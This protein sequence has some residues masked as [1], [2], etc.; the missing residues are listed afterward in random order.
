MLLPNN[1]SNN[2]DIQEFLTSCKMRLLKSYIN[3]VQALKEEKKFLNFVFSNHIFTENIAF[4][5]SGLGPLLPYKSIEGFLKKI[6]PMILLLKRDLKG[7]EKRK[8]VAAHKEAQKIVKHLSTSNSAPK[9]NLNYQAQALEALNLFKEAILYGAHKP[10]TR[11]ALEETTLDIW[12]TT[13]EPINKK[14][15]LERLKEVKV[16]WQISDITKPSL[17]R[18]ESLGLDAFQTSLETELAFHE[19]VEKLVKTATPEQFIGTLNSLCKSKNLDMLKIIIQHSNLRVLKDSVLQLKPSYQKLIQDAQKTVMSQRAS[20]IFNAPDRPLITIA[21]IRQC[22]KDNSPESAGPLLHQFCMQELSVDDII[23][24]YQYTIEHHPLLLRLL[25]ERSSAFALE[26]AYDKLVLEALNKSKTPKSAKDTRPKEEENISLGSKIYK[27][28]KHRI[29]VGMTSPVLAADTNEVTKIWAKRFAEFDKQ[30]KSIQDEIIYL[31]LH[32]LRERS[33]VEH[34]ITRHQKGLDAFQQIVVSEEF[35]ILQHISKY[36]IDDIRQYINNYISMIIYEAHNGIVEVYEI[37]KHIDYSS[38][39][40]S[41]VTDTK[42]LKAFI[43]GLFEDVPI[44]HMGAKQV[45]A[46]IIEKLDALSLQALYQSQDEVIQEA[47]QC[48]LK[49]RTGMRAKVMSLFSEESRGRYKEA[50]SVLQYTRKAENFK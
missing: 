50:R 39:I 45:L 9:F 28:F 32:F 24:L 46:K 19:I 23:E 36:Q 4:I 25:L 44:E 1:N 5:L 17:N 16:L 11:T 20:E 31:I 18:L 7:E 43:G 37:L 21:Q 30:M 13:L 6:E 8:F 49:K 47:I 35:T 22:F 26:V 33:Y 34:T 41:D 42:S 48:E 29:D 27:E 14:F 3:T 12:T 15:I 38:I 40:P 10:L 2:F